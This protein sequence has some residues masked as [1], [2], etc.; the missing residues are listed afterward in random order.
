MS[1]DILSDPTHPHGTAEGFARG[2]RGSHCPAPM[3]CRDVHFRYQG[4]YAFRKAINAGE[5]A[6]QIIERERLQAEEDALAARAP[7][8]SSK[9]TA[10]GKVAN[11]RQYVRKEPGAPI[12]DNQRQVL[13]L[14][15]EGLT[16]REIAERLGKSRDQVNATRHHLKLKPN[17][18]P[19]IADRIRKAHERGLT[20]TLIAQEL[21][22]SI[23][24]IRARRRALS[25]QP[26]PHRPL[27]LK[28]DDLVRLHTEGLTDREISDHLN[29]DRRYVARRRR[30]LALAPNSAPALSGASS[31]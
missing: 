10:P 17:R 30:K 29:V 12:T 31:S 24:Y 26:N 18:A 9:A 2:C 11:G 4:D 21:G 14:H 8:L 7:R 6:A 25:L 13:T 1:A 19:S 3:I 16:D 28:T 22:R 5:T 20:D 15:R 27:V 23:D